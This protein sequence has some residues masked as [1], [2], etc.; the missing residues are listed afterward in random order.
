MVKTKSIIIIGFFI[1]FISLLIAIVGLKQSAFSDPLL[2][3][4][5][6]AASPIEKII[7]TLQGAS[8]TSPEDIADY[9]LRLNTASSTMYIHE[10]TEMSFR[11][12][13]EFV[14]HESRQGSKDIIYVEHPPTGIAYQFYIE[15][16]DIAVNAL[17]IDRLLNT[18]SADP[19]KTVTGH[20]YNY[21]YHQH[22]RIPVLM[23]T[24][25]DERLGKYHEALFVRNGFLFQFALY[26]ANEEIA[27]AMFNQFIFGNIVFPEIANPSGVMND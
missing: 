26:V 21:L 22:T 24:V 27:E 13:K 6:I 1:G 16:T 18:I 9:W 5:A 7:N 19:Y 4:T 25:E 3:K 15:P 8:I 17:T 14:L 10:T 11:Y 20:A 23:F 2:T 12:Q